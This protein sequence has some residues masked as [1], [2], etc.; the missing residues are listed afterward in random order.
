MITTENL[1]QNKGTPVGDF[2]KIYQQSSSVVNWSPVSSIVFTS[3][4]IPI[5][6]QM[7]GA[8]DN[9]NTIDPISQSSI[10]EQQGITKVLTDFVIP[11]TTGVEATNQQ[12]YYIP[13]S[14]YRLI[15]LLGNNNLN[16]LTISV[17]WRD[18]YGGMHPMTLDAGA[19]ASMLIMLR[20]KKYNGQLTN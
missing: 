15:D 11:F 13:T 1:T 2:I 9:L 4:T 8:P 20:K 16:E 10:Y 14:E 18:K 3:G 6:P 5:E 19:S 12:I 7:S 17:F